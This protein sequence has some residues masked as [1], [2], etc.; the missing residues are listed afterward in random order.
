MTEFDNEDYAISIDEMMEQDP[1]LLAYWA[2][3][4]ADHK[5]YT[6][7]EYVRLSMDDCFNV[8]IDSGLHKHLVELLDDPWFH[9]WPLLHWTYASNLLR[10][11]WCQQDVERAINI[12]LLMA[13]KE[14]P[15]ALY[16]I[17]YCYM[18]GLKWEKSY[19]KGIDLWIQAS[20]LEYRV[21]K[22]S[23][24]FEYEYGDYK[25]LPEKLRL[26]FLR[27]VL[28]IFLQDRGINEESNSCTL[29]EREQKELNRI[30]KEIAKL[31]KTVAESER[32]YKATS[33]FWSDDEN[34][35]NLCG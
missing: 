23:L 8:E 1:K 7:D 13:K 27:E 33:L 2:N 31:E 4:E 24:N 28:R 11:A 29:S 26:R 16:D 34:P 12:L 9:Q 18:R 3:V 6:L 21:A 14:M 35:Y 17:G 30:N 5:A 25:T 20:A 15:G 10:G 32:M 19:Q 22:N